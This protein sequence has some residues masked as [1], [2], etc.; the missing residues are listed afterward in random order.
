MYLDKTGKFTYNKTE[1]EIK[2]CKETGLAVTNPLNGSIE[3]TIYESGHYQV[4]KWKLVPIILNMPD[5]IYSLFLLKFLGFNRSNTL[6]DFGCGKGYFL[7]FLKLFK[8]NN[9]GAVETSR[10]RAQFAEKLLS[11]KVNR[12]FYD[13]GKISNRR[14]DYITLFHVLEHIQSPFS[15]LDNLLKGAVNENGVIYIEVPNYHSISSMMAGKVWAHFTPHFHTNH[16]TIKSFER[17]CL[18][19]DRNFKILGTFSFY[20]GILGMSS[21]VLS[22]FGYKGSLFEDL[23]SRKFHV[24]LSLIVLSPLTIFLE[25]LSSILFNRGSVIKL[26]I[27]TK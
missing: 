12:E 18:D 20:N 5:Y 14:W 4:Q 19:S 7:F 23:K 21:A 22:K 24:I 11:F 16:F 6:I 10:P 3:S 8:Y 26:K 9:L 1:Y 13:K 2:V 17:Y 25:S 27:S 15:F